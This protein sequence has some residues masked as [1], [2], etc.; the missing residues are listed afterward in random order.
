MRHECHMGSCLTNR[1]PAIHKR[2]QSR[3]RL[4]RRKE[5]LGQSAIR[6]ISLHK[7]LG[8]GVRKHRVTFGAL[9]DQIT[10]IRQASCF[11]D[12]QSCNYL[13]THV[14]RRSC[15][16]SRQIRAHVACQLKMI[17]PDHPGM[18]HYTAVSHP[19]DSDSSSSPYALKTAFPTRVPI[20]A[21]P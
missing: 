2:E 4:W 1:W 20:K 16:D 18:V 6:C 10:Q 15:L 21:F 13:R 3:I 7:W 14:P 5:G 11:A 17:E 9:L 12:V 19:R 8:Y